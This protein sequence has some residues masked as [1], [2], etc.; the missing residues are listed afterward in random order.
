MIS[1]RAWGILGE[2]NQSQRAP[3]LSPKSRFT[4]CPI[5]PQVGK[6]SLE[7]SHLKTGKTDSETPVPTRQPTFIKSFRRQLAKNR[8]FTNNSR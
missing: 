1:P 5:D 3:L 8:H 4:V 7:R 6:L 2:G